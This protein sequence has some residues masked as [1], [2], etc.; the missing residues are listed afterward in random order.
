MPRALAGHSWPCTG[1]AWLLLPGPSAYFWQSGIVSTAR[2]GD[3]ALLGNQ[4]LQ[5]V[6]MR[7]GIAPH[8]QQELWLPLV[9]ALG[10][11]SLWQARILSRNGQPIHSALLIGCATIVMS[12]VSWT[13]HQVWTVMAGLVLVGAGNR[14]H[15]FAGACVVAVMSMSLLDL[16][17]RL[18]IGPHPLFVAANVRALTAL[19]V[20]LLGFGNLA[21][22][23]PARPVFHRTLSRARPALGVLAASLLAFAWVPV[24]PVRDPMLSFPTPREFARTDLSIAACG[25]RRAN[26]GGGCDG[27]P[28][29]PINYSVGLIEGR[30]RSLL[31]VEGY[32]SGD[33]AELAYL[34][35]PGATPVRVPPFARRDGRRGFAM[36]L[37]DPT[38]AQFRLFDRR[39]RITSSDAAGKLRDFGGSRAG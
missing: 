29:V 25:H 2:I 28:D 8:V 15:A 37:S 6:L 10:A 21:L 3:L 16:V 5:G 11:A 24:P 36:T 4:S 20:C 27:L 12:P 32:L 22:T 34:S 35:A 17:Y 39:G 18:P 14:L 31:S 30:S 1:L 23:S 26:T 9:G 33:I 7:A 38:F 19:S 13:H